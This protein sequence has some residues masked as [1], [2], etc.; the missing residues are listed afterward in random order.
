MH[1][2]TYIY[3]V[4]S[5]ITAYFLYVHFNCLFYK[6]EADSPL[7]IYN[8]IRCSVQR[9]V[10]TFFGIY[11]VFLTPW[12]VDRVEKTL[13]T[14]LGCSPREE[15]WKSFAWNRVKPRKLIRPRSGTRFSPAWTIYSQRR[16]SIAA[17]SRV[18]NLVIA[19][20]RTP[21][22]CTREIYS[23]GNLHFA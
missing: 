18:V 8:Y 3:K 13:K 10:F 2:L 21:E 5:S 14:R 16:V 22:T 19:L 9:A 17:G 6:L 12:I 4:F 15:N 11:R 1:F 20:S 7:L 23:M